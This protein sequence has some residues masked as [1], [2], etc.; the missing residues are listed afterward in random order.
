MRKHLLEETIIAI[1]E[2]VVEGQITCVDGNCRRKTIEI[3][4]E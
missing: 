1:S 2:L 4:G 3:E